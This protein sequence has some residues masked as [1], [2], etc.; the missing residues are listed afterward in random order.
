M[1]GLQ[2]LREGFKVCAQIGCAAL[3]LGALTASADEIAGE[4]TASIGDV[5]D[6]AITEGEKVNLGED[7]A[8]SI[9][10]DQDAVLELCSE[11]S[12]EL[13]KDPKSNRR[14]IALDRGEIKVVVEPRRM[15]ERI[16]IH[17]P[18]AIASLLGTVVYVSIDPK[19]QATTITSAESRVSV[20]SGDSQVQGTTILDAAQQVTVALGASPPAKPRHLDQR[21]LAELG[22]CLVDFHQTA[23]GRD[24]LIHGQR[25]AERFT[26]QDAVDYEGGKQFPPPPAKRD[27]GAL[28]QSNGASLTG[29]EDVCLSPNCG[30]IG[31]KR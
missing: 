28:P 7:G 14:I 8:C 9:L 20:R 12:L 22:G 4:I 29:Q 21:Q 26:V 6:G 30:D 24:S 10:V 19:T 17:T 25:A 18:A 16:E 3:L 11:T 5:R 31:Q 1:Y 23:L 2:A 15:D 13:R 27:G